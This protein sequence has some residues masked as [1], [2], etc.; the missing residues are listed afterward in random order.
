MCIRDSNPAWGIG[1]WVFLAVD[2][3]ENP[4]E[5]PA[6]T[7][8]RTPLVIDG[9]ERETYHHTAGG[10]HCRAARVEGVYYAAICP[11]GEAS[12]TRLVTR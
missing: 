11:A 4:T 9:A 7:R 1:E 8:D 2:R 5:P 12:E 6:P 10:L 3:D